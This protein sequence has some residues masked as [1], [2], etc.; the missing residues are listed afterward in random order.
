MLEEKIN[1]YYNQLLI[2]SYKYVHERYVIDY[3][4]SI[5]YVLKELIE[6]NN[7]RYLTNS[8][9]DFIACECYFTTHFSLI[10]RDELR[11]NY[12]IFNAYFESLLSDVSSMEKHQQDD[13]HLFTKELDNETLKNV[14]YYKNIYE[15]KIENLQRENYLDYR[16]LQ[17]FFASLLSYCLM[18][19]IMNDFIKLCERLM[20]ESDNIIDYYQFKS[21]CDEINLINP[22]DGFYNMLEEYIENSNINKKAIS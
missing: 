16:I 5:K 9:L 6:K 17:A 7:E 18:H 22:F 19:N 4:H 15:N 14:I 10:I 3:E 13:Y 12:R 20:S 2:Y 1:K 11:W 8:F 21:P